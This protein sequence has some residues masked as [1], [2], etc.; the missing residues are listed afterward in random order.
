MGRLRSLKSLKANYRNLCFRFSSRKA[1]RITQDI[2]EISDFFDCKN[3]Y[4][5]VIGKLNTLDLNIIEIDGEEYFMNYDQESVQNIQQ[6][7]TTFCVK[8]LA[9]QKKT[10]STQWKLNLV[11]LQGKP[12]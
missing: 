5:E 2:S 8:A 11:H 3:F 6:M 1:S 10:F 7:F 4:V 9:L 12:K